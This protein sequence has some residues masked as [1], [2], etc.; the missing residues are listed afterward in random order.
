M[1]VFRRSIIIPAALEQVFRF[2]RNPENL[3][4]VQPPGA[5]V[6]GSDFPDQLVQGSVCTLKVKVPF[7]IQHWKIKVEEMRLSDDRIS[8]LMVDRA[9][10]SPFPVWIH[11]HEFERQVEGTFMQ[12][13]VEFKPPGGRV[14]TWLVWPSMILLHML[15]IFRHYKT[16]QYFSERQR[17]V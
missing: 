14:S 5:T 10:I 3:S 17:Q 2:H 7:G 16:V 4:Y 6:I 9:I 11:R 12:D 1:T 8:A 15:F 13:V